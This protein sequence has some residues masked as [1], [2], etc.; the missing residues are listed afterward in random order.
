MVLDSGPVSKLMPVL[1][2]G[3]GLEKIHPIVLDSELGLE[4]W[5]P[6]NSGVVGLFCCDTR[7]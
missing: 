3:I 7:I 5:D 4:N 6:G 2:L 1:G